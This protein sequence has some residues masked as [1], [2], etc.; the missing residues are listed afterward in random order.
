MSD[1]FGDS[2]KIF[3]LIKT[4]EKRRIKKKRMTI[5]KELD[6]KSRPPLRQDEKDGDPLISKTS[7]R[8]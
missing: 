1:I 4:G 2:L 6:F 8:Y 5:Y 7:T 3:D